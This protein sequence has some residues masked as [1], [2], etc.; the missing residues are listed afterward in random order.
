MGRPARVRATKPPSKLAIGKER[1]NRLLAVQTH[2]CSPRHW[3]FASRAGTGRFDLGLFGLGAL[4]PKWDLHRNR[5]VEK[6]I[7]SSVL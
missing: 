6:G 7:V 4:P 3:L 1:G 2:G 5:F